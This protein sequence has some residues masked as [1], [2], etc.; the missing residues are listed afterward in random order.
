MIV[1][2]KRFDFVKGV[3]T[4]HTRIVKRAPKRPS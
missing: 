4:L 2:V 3:V 1:Q